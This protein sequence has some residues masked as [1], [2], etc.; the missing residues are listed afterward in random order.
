MI[1]QSCV[2]VDFIIVFYRRCWLT[3]RILVSLVVPPAVLLIM[4]I[5]LLVSNLK[6]CEDRFVAEA[7]KEFV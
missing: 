4:V 3:E 5:D 2:S 1:F 6:K 7:R